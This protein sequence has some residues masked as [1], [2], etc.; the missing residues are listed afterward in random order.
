[1]IFKRDPPIPLAMHMTEYEKKEWFKNYLLWINWT[2]LVVEDEP[3][4][5][6]YEYDN[7]KCRITYHSIGYRNMQFCAVPFFERCK[8]H[9][10]RKK[11]IW[12]K[13]NQVMKYVMSIWPAKYQI[14]KF[15][16]CI[17]N[18]ERQVE[19]EVCRNSSWGATP[20]YNWFNNEFM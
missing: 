11:T 2:L 14:T 15:M 17:A 19:H 6:I 4:D 13:I 3:K 12:R 20:F 5:V 7:K 8:M 10:S 18:Q 1:M 9:S 16:C